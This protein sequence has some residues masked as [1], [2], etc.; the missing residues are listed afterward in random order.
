MIDKYLTKKSSI[1]A[2]IGYALRA[3]ARKPVLTGLALYRTRFL[4]I[5]WGR[6]GLV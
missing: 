6:K 3:S 2:T 4:A 1:H 5:G